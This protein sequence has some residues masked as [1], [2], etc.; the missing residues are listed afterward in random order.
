MIQRFA[1]RGLR[2]LFEQGD[3]RRLPPDQIRKL[4]RILH[5]LDLAKTSQ[6]MNIPGWRLHKLKGELKAYWAVWVTGNDR[7]WFK[8]EDGHVWDVNYGD[9]H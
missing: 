7:V 2:Q 5:Q 6:D 9:Y 8:F 3:E 4:K 1:H